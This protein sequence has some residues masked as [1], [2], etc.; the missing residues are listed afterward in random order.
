MYRI[1]FSNNLE[2]EDNNDDIYSIEIISKLDNSKLSFGTVSSVSLSLKLNNKDKRFNSFTFKNKNITLYIN[3]VKKYK[4]YIDEV[5]MKNG[6][7]N[8]IAYDKIADLDK[9]FKGVSFPITLNSLII[10][11]LA[12]AGITLKTFMF[13]NQGFV[14]HNADLSGMTCRDVLGYCMELCG[15]IGLLNEE[16]KFVIRWFEKTEAKEINANNFISYSSDEEDVEFNNVRFSR[17]NNT[18]DSNKVKSDIKGTIYI[19]SD[20]PLLENSTSEKIKSLISNFDV[21]YLSYFPCKIQIS[22]IE[23]YSLGDCL[24]FVDEDGN[25]KIMLVS[26]ISIKNMSNVE[27]ESLGIDTTVSE[28][29]EE[30]PGTGNTGSGFG[31]VQIKNIINNEE[32]QF[33]DCSENTR[34]FVSCTMTFQ[35]S[36]GNI[37]FI[38]NND[39]IRTYTPTLGTNTFTFT[40]EKPENSENILSFVSSNTYSYIEFSFIYCNCLIVDYSEEDSELDTGEEEAV[41]PFRGDKFGGL[42]FYIGVE[43]WIYKKTENK[44]NNTVT[45]KLFWGTAAEASA[46]HS[47]D[48]YLCSLYSTRLFNNYVKLKER[49][50]YVKLEISGIISVQNSEETFSFQNAIPDGSTFIYSRKRNGILKYYKSSTG[51]I[52]MKNDDEIYVYLSEPLSKV[53]VWK[54]DNLIF[55]Y[56][57]L[58]EDITGYKLESRIPI[59]KYNYTFN[60]E[61]EQIYSIKGTTDNEGVLTLQAQKQGYVDVQGNQNNYKVMMLCDHFYDEGYTKTESIS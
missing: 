44:T 52:K 33:S 45:E 7:I 16:E 18:Y 61:T 29:D 8:I 24:S 37:Q 46:A 23:K 31:S 41:A 38:L 21:K 22:S 34:I 32:V 43:N 49:E 4:F 10:E 59:E 15:G 14:I 5:K 6:F 57:L 35:T 55:S 9:N 47:D 30:D 28:T 48:N 27:V 11:A 39:T 2:I 54:L 1:V 40:I 20:N 60:E 17:G 36:T 19:T 50:F 42:F 51:I 26:N 56:T 13:T 58:D 12:Q 25:K 3:N 53:R